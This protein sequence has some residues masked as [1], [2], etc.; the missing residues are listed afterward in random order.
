MKQI[1]VEK[2]LQDLHHPQLKTILLMRDLI[3][4]F[5]VVENI[6]WNSF[7]YIYNGDDRLTFNLTGKGYFRIILH[8]GVKVSNIDIQKLFTDEKIELLTWL[9]KNRAIIKIDD[10]FDFNQNIVQLKSIISLWLE[11]TKI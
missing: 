4:Q 10:N 2:Y 11:K 3:L 1:T 5:D 9:T 6:K 8:T 7:N